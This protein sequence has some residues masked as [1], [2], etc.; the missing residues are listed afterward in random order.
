[1]RKKGL[2]GL[3]ERILVGSMICAGFL[4]TTER[5]ELIDLARDGL[6]EHR[7]ARRANALVLLDQGMSCSDIG[8]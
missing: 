2:R 4:S 5:T 3:L 6:V 8:V 1:M 7:L